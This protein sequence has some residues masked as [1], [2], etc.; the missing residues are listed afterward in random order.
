MKEEKASASES[1]DEAWRADYKTRTTIQVMSDSEADAFSPFFFESPT[2][3]R[4]Y[5]R[6]ITQAYSTRAHVN[7]CSQLN[8]EKKTT[9]Y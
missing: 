9:T 7:A 5:S 2:P 4:Y 8:G 3:P 1:P 6:Q